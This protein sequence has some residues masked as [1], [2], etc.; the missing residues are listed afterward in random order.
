LYVSGK[1]GL[2]KE[3]PYTTWYAARNTDLGRERLNVV[4]NLVKYADDRPTYIELMPDH[5]RIDIAKSPSKRQKRTELSQNLLSMVQS[6]CEW[7][8][9]EVIAFRD[10]AWRTQLSGIHSKI[11]FH[12]ISLSILALDFKVSKFIERQHYFYSSDMFDADVAEETLRQ[13][14]GQIYDVKFPKPYTKFICTVSV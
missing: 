8:D 14:Y 3:F 4:L 7:V 10:L 13:V 1:E 12:V 2:S 5:V 6:F 11:V 9:M